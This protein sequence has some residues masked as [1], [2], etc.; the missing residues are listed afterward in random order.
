MSILRLIY[1]FYRFE[2]NSPITAI[3]SNGGIEVSEIGRKKISV[4]AEQ[5]RESV[6]R[7]MTRVALQY[8]AVNLG[9]GSLIFPVPWS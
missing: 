5:F 7:E 8:G 6:I 2:K 3:E 4:K 9:R 1:R